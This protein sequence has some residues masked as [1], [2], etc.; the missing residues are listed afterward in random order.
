MSVDANYDHLA[1]HAFPGGRVTVP[2]WLNRLWAD[3]TGAD[4]PSPLVHPLLVYYV[5]V[6]G[7]GVTFGD[8]FD[9]MEAPHDSGVMVGE[10]SLEFARA[11]EVG[12]EYDVAG[13][14]TDVVR[15]QGKRA[16]TFDMLTFVLTL[17]EAGA[18]DAAATSTM[19][20]I[21]PRGERSA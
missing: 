1:G 8:I 11:I 18:S 14:I 13:G 20:F 21:F 15:K 7:S 6:E 5:A 12:R 17:T 10:Q 2:S 19:T 3:S 9:L 4:D 16:G